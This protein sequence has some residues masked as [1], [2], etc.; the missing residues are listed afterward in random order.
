M[1]LATAGGNPLAVQMFLANERVDPFAIDVHGNTALHYAARAFDEEF[2]EI[3]FFNFA[4][5]ISI[6]HLR[7][8]LPQKNKRSSELIGCMELLMQAGLDMNK[9]NHA[10]YCPEL[11]ATTPEE[12]RQWWYEKFTKQTQEV[13]SNLSGAATAVSVTAALVATAS[14]VG[15]LQ[16]P[17]GFDSQ[18]DDWLI[19]YA[20]FSHPSVEAFMFCDNLTFYFSMSSIILAMIPFLPIS[21]EGI[22]REIRVVQK[23]VQAAVVVLFMSVVFLICAFFCAAV[24]VVPKEYWRYK[25]LTMFTTGSGGMICVVTLTLFC[26]R[27]LRVIKIKNPFVLNAYNAIVQNLKSDKSTRQIADVVHSHMVVKR[28]VL[29]WKKV[30]K[31]RRALETKSR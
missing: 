16:P 22:L 26:L 12:V 5:Y 19:G 1:S 14:F 3:Y 7:H 24:S 2:N 21:H 9:T 20:Q 6:E 11:C 17:L 8:K 30:V 28:V 27:L 18:G 15:P 23:S 31:R 4:D 25:S 10:G 13:L 29:R